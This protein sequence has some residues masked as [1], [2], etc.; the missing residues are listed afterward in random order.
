MC[1]DKNDIKSMENALKQGIRESKLSELNPRLS[2]RASSDTSVKDVIQIMVDKKIGAVLLVEENELVGIFSERDIISKIALNYDDVKDD[3]ISDYMTPEPVHLNIDDTIAFALNRMDV[4]GYRH[5]PITD[6]A[7][8][9]TGIV[10]VR[11]IIRY[12]DYK[13]LAGPE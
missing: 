1:S 11:D 2:V 12:I 10:A 3:P 13:C 5:I 6:D 9:P 8:I 4:G 7:N